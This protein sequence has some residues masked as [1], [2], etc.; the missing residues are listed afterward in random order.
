MSFDAF[1]RGG[2]DDGEPPD[3]NHTAYLESTSVFK[4]KKDQWWLRTCWRTTDMAY[5]WETL[6]GLEGRQTDR[7]RELVTAIGVDLEQLN[8]FEDLGDE[9][10]QFENEEYVVDV[11]RNGEFLNTGVV[12]RAPKQTT[13]ATG[14][15]RASAPAAAA[16]EQPDVPID[17]SDFDKST[18]G[19]LFDDDDDIPF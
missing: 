19:G 1:K 3:G 12:Q 4:S 13:M 14:G 15:G 18:P 11:Q 9:L 17:T 7:A 2:G 16:G 6:R 10:A 5:Y 8:S